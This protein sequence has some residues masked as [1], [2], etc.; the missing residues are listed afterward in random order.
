[1]IE[2]YKQFSFEAAHSLQPHSGLHGH[3]FRV[4]VAFTGE[5]D[6]VFGWAE[7]LDAA[8]K[9][10]QKL[11]KVLDHSHLNDIEGL[12]NPSLENLAK[13]VWQKLAEDFS[14][15]SKVSVARGP[16]GLAEG[17]T[18]SEAPQAA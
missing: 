11:W 15:L 6:P 3:T 13:W 18:Y 9:K 4:G 2:T 14:T 12:E 1:M 10:I 8:D 5:P 7:N 16:E 17:C